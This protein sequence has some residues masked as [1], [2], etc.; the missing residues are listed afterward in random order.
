MHPLMKWRQAAAWTL[1]AG[2]CIAAAAAYG[3]EETE[4]V[5]ILNA[6]DPYGPAYLQIDAAMR[7][8]FAE[9]T[10]RRIVL[11]SE[12]LDA[13]RFPEESLDPEMLALMTKKYRKVHIDVV[14]AMSAVALEFFERHGEQLWPGARLVLF[15]LPG[16]TD[17][18]TLPPNTIGFVARDDLAGTMELARR[19]QPNARRILVISGVA[20]VDLELE[21]RARQVVPAMAGGATVEFLS[22][23]PLPELVHRVAGEP[24]NTIVILLAQFLDRN[25]GQYTYREV[26]HALSSASAAPVYGLY[27]SGIGFGEVAGSMENLADG[28]K[29]VGQLVRDTLAGH[30]PE[31]GKAMFTVPS[32]CV[33][34]AREMQRRSLDLRRLPSGCEIRFADRPL[35]HQY[36]WQILIMLAIIAAQTMLIA[37][38][39]AQRRRRRVAES[40]SQKRYSEMA[41]M[42]RR[43]T[44]GEMSG[45]I[46]HELNQPL[47]AIRN[48]A[49]AA[50]LLLKADPP[51]LG[52]VAEILHDI[53]RDDQRASDVIAR[54]RQL[55]RKSEFELRAMDLNEAIDESM[56]LLATEA[57]ANEVSLLAELAP[58][59]PKVSADRVEVQQVILNL[60]CN[61]VEAME[62]QPVEKKVLTI[63]SGRANDKEAEVSVADLG[64]GIPADS[65]G[66]IFDAFVTTK[67]NGMGLGLAISRTIIEAH[68]GHI[69]AEN[70]PDGGAVIR[71]TLPFASASPA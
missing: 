59:L 32:R 4:R 9:A 19:L 8:S 47:G 42:N 29:L 50:E 45:A 5:L 44:L 1:I 48:N 49:S 6:L 67:P 52:E 18:S 56:R 30:S 69:R 62:G 10:A 34:D 70:K 54:I 2:L 68:G 31:P 11:Y 36:W 35:W 28:A 64:V 60:V 53:K 46:A 63:R 14:V 17:P 66:G 25:G 39:F 27:E 33:A 58:G 65:I 21:K 57:L 40:S 15:S 23:W 61:A 41:L 71:F 20:P 22:G 55:L 13:Q 43:V 37:A 12:Q 51:K 7:A 16:V 38:L 26:L 3:A 24:A